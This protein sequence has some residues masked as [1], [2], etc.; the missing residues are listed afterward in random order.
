MKIIFTDTLRKFEVGQMVSTPKGNGVIEEIREH[1]AYPLFVRFASGK[2]NAFL[3]SEIQ[4]ANDTKH[5][6]VGK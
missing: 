5:I 6:G 3:Q 2:L 1:C 4:E